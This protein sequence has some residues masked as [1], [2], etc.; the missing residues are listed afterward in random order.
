V[1]LYGVELLQLSDRLLGL[2]VTSDGESSVSAYTLNWQNDQIIAPL[3]GLTWELLYQDGDGWAE[4]TQRHYAYENSSISYDAI[5][6]T[7]NSN[8]LNNTTINYWNNKVDTGISTPVSVGD[9]EITQDVTFDEARLSNFDVYNFVS[10]IN[11]SDAIDVLRHIVDL[12]AITEG[13]YAY[14][15][16]DVNNDGNINI[17]D[18]HTMCASYWRFFNEQTFAP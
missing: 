13:S 14:H 1:S 15:A 11:I 16:A 8:Y 12:E 7:D 2:S 3:K 18:A 9:I 5:I 17:S 10:A 6:K 4:H